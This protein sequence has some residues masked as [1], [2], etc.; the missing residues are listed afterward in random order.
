MINFTKMHGIGNDFVILDGIGSELPA[1][2]L[3]ELSQ[4]MCSRHRGIGADGLILVERGKN[5]PW[6][7]RM[8]NPDGSE[9]E[10]CGNGLRCFARYLLDLGYE[11]AAEFPVET[12]AG[13]LVVS[14]SKDKIKVDMGRYSV[15]PKGTPTP[16]LPYGLYGFPVSMGNPHLV[17]F[18]PDVAAVPLAT[19]G[20]EL[21]NHAAFPERT[22]VHFVQ[23]IDRG[24]VRM[25]TWERG[26]GITLACGTGACSVGV[27]SSL[28]G[29][30]EPEVRIQLP[31]GELFIEVR[32]DQHVMMSGTTA[33][34]FSGVWPS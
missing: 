33:T 6:R 21:E 26:A 4:Q 13:V 23:V 24:N 1:G 9:S 3:A 16:I 20:P 22:N 14:S 10:M 34:V 8:L 19:W 17:I 32:L 28:T 5:A 11:K 27:V 18:V 12:G 2:N 30:S 25:R 31:G 7:M 15:P 29:K